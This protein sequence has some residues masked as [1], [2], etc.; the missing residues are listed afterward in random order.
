M[1]DALGQGGLT[2]EELGAQGA[3]ALPDKEVV[4]ILDLNADIDLAIDAAAPIDLAVAANANVAAP[5]DAAVGA[6]V[7][8]VGSTAQALERPGRA[9]STRAS[10]PT[11][12]R[13]PT[14]SARLDQSNDV[15]RRC[16]A[17]GAAG[18][19]TAAHARRATAAAAR[20]RRG[21]WS[22]APRTRRRRT[23]GDRCRRRCGRRCDRR[24]G[25]RVGE[26]HRWRHSTAACS[27]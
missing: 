18:R 24:R 6:N 22:T 11:R 21:D 4:S 17:E 10:T 26:R 2:E 20:V 25:R 5:I 15:A 7:L 14:R 19:S 23:A 8:S 3:T 27:T 16:P 12:R 9:R 13:T 1:A